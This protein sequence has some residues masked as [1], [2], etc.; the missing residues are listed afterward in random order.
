MYSHGLLIVLQLAVLTVGRSHCRG[1]R[2]WSP[3]SVFVVIVAPTWGG[4]L[5]SA[6]ASITRVDWVAGVV[7]AR[8]EVMASGVCVVLA[9]RRA[10]SLVIGGS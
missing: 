7:V 2:W 5:A 9:S 6:V 10:W 8:V 1:R 4:R 3:R